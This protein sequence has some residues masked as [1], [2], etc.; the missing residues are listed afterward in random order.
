MAEKFVPAMIVCDETKR[1]GAWKGFGRIFA[2]K[3]LNKKIIKKTFESHIH[4]TQ[5]QLYT[6][7]QKHE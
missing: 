3:C 4:F 6:R 1:E 5:P 2:T 7:K